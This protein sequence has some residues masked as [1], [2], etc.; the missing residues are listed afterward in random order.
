M[1]KTRTQKALF[2]TVSSLASEI[3]S[4]VCGLILPRLILARF[5]SAY[6][7]ISSSTLQL[8]SAVSILTVGISG[9][10]RVALY[11]SLADHD[12]EKTSRI[13]KATELYVRKVGYALLCLM[14]I[15]IVF[16]PM[17]VDTGYSWLEV[18]PL[19]I[20]AG[21][22]A[23]GQYYLGLTYSA[24]LM[25]DQRVYISNLT[26]ILSNI[27][28]LIVSVILIRAN[29]SIQVVR[30]CSSLV[31]LLNPV[32]K[33]IY[34]RHQYKL[35][36]RCTP[37]NSA[38]A[39][40]RDV[41]AHSIA[42]IVHDHTD[43]IV[44]TL[45]TNVKIV[46][47]YTV[48]NFVMSALKKTQTVFTN[49]TEAIFGSMWVKGEEDKIAEYLTLFEY[50]ICVFVSVVFSTSYAVIL[51][52]I[53]NYT[54]NV[55]DV[56]YVLP[57]Y[58]AVIT[59]AQM[60]YAFRTPYLAVIHGAGHYKQTKNAAYAEAII[61]LSLSVIL[62]QFLGIV[63]VAIG[64]LAANLF[65]TVQYAVYTEKNLVRRGGYRFIER[66]FWASMNC[67]IVIL[68]HYALHLQ[69]YAYRDWASWMLI[70]AFTLVIA[71][72]VTVISS[73]VFHRDDFFAL[74]KLLKRVIKKKR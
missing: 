2:N 38:L 73:C 56:E 68:V 65:R 70:S 63:G 20:A 6:N 31:L 40:R 46:S 44:L 66:I 47:V 58:A 18:A 26:L 49:G 72:F 54:R 61:N 50:I 53:S 25:A 35:N 41:M 55:T 5:G 74:I 52:F 43:V 64:T 60:L 24:L 16:Y 42:N 9:S 57:A 23:A 48:Y 19:I 51:P 36:S 3:V 8:L 32:M 37:E 22:S 15:L 12:T 1:A 7:G 34:C 45:F 11:R 69:Q 71:V 21:I 59:T 39:M 30:V 28:N 13:I 14:P 62:V 10:T 27:L 17:V 4:L 33:A 29:C 67:G